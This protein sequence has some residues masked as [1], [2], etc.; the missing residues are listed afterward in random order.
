MA[1]KQAS[2]GAT[3]VVAPANAAIEATIRELLA[4]YPTLTAGYYCPAT[5]DVRFSDPTPDH[6]EIKR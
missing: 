3:D 1:K 2:T 6:Y 4:R 5:G